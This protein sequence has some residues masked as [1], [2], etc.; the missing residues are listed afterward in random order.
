MI[1]NDMFCDSLTDRLRFLSM[2][3]WLRFET[4]VIYDTTPDVGVEPCLHPVS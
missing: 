2:R 4:I 1:N 3:C